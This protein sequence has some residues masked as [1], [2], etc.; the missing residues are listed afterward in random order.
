MSNVASFSKDLQKAAAEADADLLGRIL[1]G[2]PASIVS[3]P[4]KNGK[5]AIHIAAG[6]GSAKC[7]ELLV[8]AG[9]NPEATC[10]AGRTAMHYA[11]MTG[12][13]PAVEA[14]CSA[15]K[16]ATPPLFS[17]ADREGN[18]P[19]HLA[20]QAGNFAAVRALLSAGASAAVRNDEGVSPLH[21]AARGGF[22]DS[23]ELLIESGVARMIG[24]TDRNKRTPIMEASAGAHADVVKL[25]CQAKARPTTACVV[26]A[27]GH[28]D[29]ADTLAVLFGEVDEETQ[30]Q[31]MLEGWPTEADLAMSLA[32]ERGYTRN[33]KALLKCAGGTEKMKVKM[34]MLRATNR[35]GLT[36]LHA[37]LTAGHWSAALELL[38]AGASTKVATTA[39]EPLLFDLVPETTPT[40]VCHAVMQRYLGELG[41]LDVLNGSGQTVLT[42][43]IAAGGRVDLVNIMLACGADVNGA[44]VDG[45]RSVSVDSPLI[46]AVRTNQITVVETLM[47]MNSV[48]RCIDVNDQD[49]KGDSALS[50]ADR[51]GKT[52]I[53]QVLLQYGAT[54]L[55]SSESPAGSAISARRKRRPSVRFAECSEVVLL[56]STG[57]AADD[58]AAAEGADGGS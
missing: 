45:E 5:V 17:K 47:A 8:N 52:E 54:P 25:L 29:G 50:I 32:A 30:S 48:L 11:A 44:D 31:L 27:A 39:G 53:C 49:A 36:P 55:V 26:E 58:G 37:A 13:A 23:V 7:F 12:G 28:V 51:D 57:P 40:Y 56:E 4:D 19:L 22:H 34:A 18:T 43:A 20:T 10:H 42:A 6:S 9:A 2:A 33:I 35:D 14:I 41:D 38:H 21:N 46:A 16:A 24:S 15:S 1:D 3:K